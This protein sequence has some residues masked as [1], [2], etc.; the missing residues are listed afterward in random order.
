M[1]F[2]FKPGRKATSHSAPSFDA[3]KW[4]DVNIDPFPVDT[5]LS[6]ALRA[7]YTADLSFWLDHM[8]EE[9]SRIARQGTSLQR[10]LIDPALAGNPHR[11]D[12][13]ERSLRLEDELIQHVRDVVLTETEADRHWQAFAVQEREQYALDMFYG[14]EATRERLIGIAWYGK[15]AAFP[16]PQGFRINRLWLQSLPFTVL[17]DL[18]IFK[19]FTWNPNPPPESLFSA[20]VQEDV[21]WDVV[22]ETG[23]MR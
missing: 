17:I 1:A 8:V 2:E 23:G 3:K 22:R 15:A 5:S 19:V 4:E 18:R 16:W 10:K 13:V 6:V 7:S 11:P 20:D 14:V 9:L 21:P 12:A